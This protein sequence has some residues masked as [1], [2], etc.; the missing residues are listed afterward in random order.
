MKRENI[1][2][3]VVGEGDAFDD[4]KRIQRE[5]NLEN[6]LILTGRRP[7]EEIPGLIAAADI[8]V[9]PADPAEKV[10]HDGLPAKIY[11]YLAMQKP[12]IST[13]LA[14]VM[15][16]FGEGNGVVY[17]DRPEDTIAKALELVGNDQVKKLGLQARQFVES[18]SWDKIAAQFER[19]LEDAVR[20]LSSRT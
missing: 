7:Y 15:R 6:T 1:K 4:L 5:H 9:L 8:C 12:M 3:L 18:Y 14:G 16:E 10:M 20:E 19:I 2:F 13:K 17:V 11:E